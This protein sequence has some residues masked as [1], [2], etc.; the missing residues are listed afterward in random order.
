MT[1]FLRP[2][3]PKTPSDIFAAMVLSPTAATGQ[4]AHIPLFSICPPTPPSSS[5]FFTSPSTA[6]LPAPE[7]EPKEVVVHRQLAANEARQLALLITQHLHPVRQSHSGL[8]RESIALAEK[9]HEAGVRRDKKR[10]VMGTHLRGVWEEGQRFG[11]G[12]HRGANG[13]SRLE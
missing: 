1:T 4:P 5:P 12:G 2:I 7:P 11:G 3:S 10:R 8:M 9:L 13:Y 6:G